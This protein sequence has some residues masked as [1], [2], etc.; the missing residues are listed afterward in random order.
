FCSNHGNRFPR[1]GTAPA[2]LMCIAE[3]MMPRLIL[4]L[5]QHFRENRFCSN[6][7]NRF[8]RPGTAPAELMCIAEAMMPRLILRLLQHFRENR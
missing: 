1:P 4:R 2:E 6:H 7:G 8:P 5:L 3:A